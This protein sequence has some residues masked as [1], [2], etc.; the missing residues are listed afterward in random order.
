MNNLNRTIALILPKI[1][2][3]NTFNFLEKFKTNDFWYRGHE[4][5]KNFYDGYYMRLSGN[6]K[7]GDIIIGK[8][9]G[10]FLI[11]ECSP[12]FLNRA[13]SDINRI[14]SVRVYRR[15]TNA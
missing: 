12:S 8:K 6:I 15:N 5:P 14:F 2:V 9:D 11:Y 3:S 10:C 1:S 13:I 4:L 7:P